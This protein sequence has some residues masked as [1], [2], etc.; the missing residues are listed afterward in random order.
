MAYFL[1]LSMDCGVGGGFMYSFVFIC[2]YVRHIEMHYFVWK[3]LYKWSLNDWLVYVYTLV[4]FLSCSRVGDSPIIGAGAYADSS[5]GGA[6]ATGDGDI[7]M[8]FVPRYLPYPS[9]SFK[10]KSYKIKNAFHVL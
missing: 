10:K 3:V 7:M 8:R 9:T 5:A 6:A 2:L 1:T 4:I